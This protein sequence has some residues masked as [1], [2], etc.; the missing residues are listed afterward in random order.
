MRSRT[1]SKASLVTWRADGNGYYENF[2]V[3]GRRFRG[4]LGT[5]QQEEAET[6]A[7]SRYAAA[8]A[9][10]DQTAGIGVAT[11]ET[12]DQVL[13]VYW[14]E[15]GQFLP[16][17][18]DITRISRTLKA[19]LGADRRVAELT[20]AELRRYAARR[21]GSVSN[22]SVNIELVHLRSVLN[23]AKKLAGVSVP[24]ICWRDVLLKEAG[25]R[26]HVLSA[27]DEERRLFAALRDDYHPMV[28]F[29]LFSGMR[30]SNVLELTWRQID[31]D[32][33]VVKLII[34]GGELDYKPITP[35]M[36]AI[37]D[38]E[39]GNNFERVFT[40]VCARNRHDPKTGLR[41]DKGT[42]YPFTH[43][44]WRKEWKRALIEAGIEDFRFHDLR[45]TAATRVLRATGNLQLVQK[46]LGHKV[47]A[48]TLRYTKSDLADLRA[49]MIAGQQAAHS[50][51]EIVTEAQAQAKK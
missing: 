11:P 7:A 40:Y 45:H 24:E 36:G 30:L 1:K 19:G 27:D 8:L 43:D 34:K 6:R 33:G 48:T 21:R 50:V 10:E 23:R 5:D 42:R 35:L 2:S 13:G 31:R 39:R 17:A 44:G 14:L 28:L 29:A 37:L 15:H 16:S 46:M 47:I 20:L 51:T 3:R 38:R 32:A 49:A 4:S 9:G 22:R 41:Q 18:A 26:E 12:L 25:P